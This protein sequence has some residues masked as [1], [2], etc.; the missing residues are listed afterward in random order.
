MVVEVNAFVHIVVDDT[1]G[2][3]G[4]K[5]TTVSVLPGRFFIV[6][7]DVTVPVQKLV[8]SVVGFGGYSTN[9]VS[10]PPTVLMNVDFDV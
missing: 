2:F 8:F 3:G 1:V 5:A 6:L 7:V 10:V 9:T 4:Y